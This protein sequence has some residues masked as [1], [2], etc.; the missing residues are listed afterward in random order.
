MKLKDHYI[1]GEPVISVAQAARLLSLEANPPQPLRSGQSRNY[2]SYYAAI[3]RARRNAEFG[4]HTIKK[5]IKAETFF[6]WAQRKYAFD[7]TKYT[8]KDNSSVVVK[9]TGVQL[10]ASV[11]SDLTAHSLAN[12]RRF[13]LKKAMRQLIHQQELKIREQNK[14]LQRLAEIDA[15]RVERSAKARYHGSFG[16]RPKSK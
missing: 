7:H 8:Q 3:E 10:V 13:S 4:K 1:S 6:D 12:S 11:S 16:G 15:Q 9:V 2:N 5:L 14:D